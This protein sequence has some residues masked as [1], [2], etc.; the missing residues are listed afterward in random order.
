[1]ERPA[2]AACWPAINRSFGH[3]D[4]VIFELKRLT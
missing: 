1:M 2:L 3:I 4:T